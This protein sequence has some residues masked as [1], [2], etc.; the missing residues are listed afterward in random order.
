MRGKDEVACG[1]TAEM[2]R[3]PR[4]SQVSQAW[5]WKKVDILGTFLRPW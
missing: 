5:G 4:K 1:A 3:D 2:P